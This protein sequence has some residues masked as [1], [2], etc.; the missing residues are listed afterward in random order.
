MIFRLLLRLLKVVRTY[1]ETEPLPSHFLRKCFI[2]LRE[3][4]SHQIIC[5]VGV[6]VG[7]KIS[8]RGHASIS[9]ELH[10]LCHV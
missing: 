4:G 7:M 9:V 3:Q 8:Y 5:L 10:H 2:L 6:P 1:S